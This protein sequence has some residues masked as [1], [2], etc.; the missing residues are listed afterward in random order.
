MHHYKNDD[1]KN[2]GERVLKFFGINYGDN[3]INPA[4]G[5][6]EDT[7][8]SHQ[9][10]AASLE[11]H[12]EETEYDFVE[13]VRRSLHAVQNTIYQTSN[14]DRLKQLEQA[15]NGNVLRDENGNVVHKDNKPVY[16]DRPLF[17]IGPNGEE[18]NK[19]YLADLGNL[20]GEYSQRAAN[21]RTASVDRALFDKK[22]G[23][24]GLAYL[25]LATSLRSLNAV[26][27]NPLSAAT[28]IAP[29]KF[30]VGIVSAEDFT[31]AIASTSAQMSGKAKPDFIATYSNFVKGRTEHSAEERAIQGKVID[32]G[33]WMS[34]AADRFTTNVMVRALFNH[35]LRILGDKDAALVQAEDMA[36]AMLADKSRVGRSWFYENQSLGGLLGQFQQESVN[37]FMYMLKDMKYYGGGKVP[38][39][40]AMMLGVFVFN[41]IFNLLRGSSAMPD[42]IGA[43]V[44]TYNEHKN[45]D[46]EKTTARKAVDY[47]Q[48]VAGAIN[49][50]DFFGTGSTAVG[51][52]GEDIAEYLDRLIDGEEDI[53]GFFSVLGSTF[54]PGGTT[55]RRAV[56]GIKSVSQGY[57]E[58]SKGNV[59]HDINPSW[60][61]YPV[62]AIIGTNALPDAWGYNYWR[63]TS[64]TAKESKNFKK[65]VE[66]GMKPSEAWKTIKGNNDASALSKAAVDA[67]SDADASAK[68]IVDSERAAEE[69]RATAGLPSNTAA[70]AVEGYSGG[71]ENDPVNVGISLWRKY[72]FETYP[73][74]YEDERADD[75]YRKVF[76]MQVGMYLNG[77]YGNV[78]SKDAAEGLENALRKART[79]INK[80]YSTDEEN[81]EGGDLNG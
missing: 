74:A 68:E 6:T 63:E 10:N 45:S 51:G 72:G 73:R 20:F 35:E 16:E 27:F 29:L 78:G 48:A 32:A 37:E 33:Y 50:V 56:T 62:A 66:S 54:F 4:L 61:K 43:V 22:L 59:K 2:V 21:K 65:L 24:K 75:E 11:R 36:R 42:P 9:F 57:A 3:E 67:N 60:W 71:D 77:A 47:V 55:L 44:E 49:P 76:K 58:N 1:P 34:A 25:N 15:I 7:R 52:A 23:R 80:K 28:N 8:P 17:V 14:I 81:K 39:A 19:G 18:I 40:L 13:S 5:D 12:G 53:W 30:L 31:S 46:E 26:A 70:W 64:L 41:A 79:K 69:S 38:K